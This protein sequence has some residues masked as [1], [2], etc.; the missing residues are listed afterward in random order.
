MEEKNSL[1]HV[2]HGTSVQLPHAAMS[3]TRLSF[4]LTLLVCLLFLPD[5]G[6]PEELMWA[7]K[8]DFISWKSGGTRFAIAAATVRGSPK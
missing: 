2:L 5:L 4:S 1:R 3:P 8:C 7:V 6:R